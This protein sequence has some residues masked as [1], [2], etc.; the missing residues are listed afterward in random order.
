MTLEHSYT[1][2]FLPVTLVSQ[3]HLSL[4]FNPEPTNDSGWYLDRGL[5]HKYVRV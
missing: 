4:S 5:Y 3:A 1:L 2:T